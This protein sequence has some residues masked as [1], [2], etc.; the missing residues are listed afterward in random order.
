MHVLTRPRPVFS[1]MLL[2]PVAA[3][4]PT[5]RLVE[6]TAWHPVMPTEISKWSPMQKTL[7][8]VRVVSSFALCR[9]FVA[10]RSSSSSSKP[11]TQHPH[12][13]EFGASQLIP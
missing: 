12:P 5:T 4:N 9:G 7:Y 1:S 11:P 2:F 8:Q 6:D 13:A 3:T 10:Q